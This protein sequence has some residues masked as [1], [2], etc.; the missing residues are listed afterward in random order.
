VAVLFCVGRLI[1]H[2]HLGGLELQPRAVVP[3]VT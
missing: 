2:G 1:D 3:S